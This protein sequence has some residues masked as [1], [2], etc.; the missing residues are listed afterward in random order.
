MEAEFDRANAI[1]LAAYRQKYGTEPPTFDIESQKANIV[2]NLD[3]NMVPKQRALEIIRRLVQA[4]EVASLPAS[5]E[6][7]QSQ[8]EP[9]TAPAGA[10]LITALDSTQTQKDYLKPENV[11]IPGSSR[12]QM[13]STLPFKAPFASPQFVELLPISGPALNAKFPLGMSRIGGIFIPLPAQLPCLMLEIEPQDEKQTSV[14][15]TLVSD[16][17]EGAYYRCETP[18]EIGPI[19]TMSQTRK[20]W[21]RDCRNEELSFG[22]DAT[23][24]QR[25]SVQGIQSQKRFHTLTLADSSFVTQNVDVSTLRVLDDTGETVGPMSKLVPTSTVGTYNA[26]QNDEIQE[27]QIYAVEMPTS[28][29]GPVSVYISLASPALAII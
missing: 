5:Q 22:T 17:A 20:V 1:V 13:S 9:Q 28:G 12:I 10:T 15:L 11:K 27:N 18:L 26:L 6:T 21:L 29:T 2:K 23:I 7:T 8:P 25:V 16:T 19:A 24:G 3:E 14:L 4:Y